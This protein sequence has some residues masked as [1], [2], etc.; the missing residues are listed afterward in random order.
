MPFLS[1][2]EQQ[3]QK[4]EQGVRHKSLH[5]FN[6]TN[7]Y[8]LNWSGTKATFARIRIQKNFNVIQSPIQTHWYPAGVLSLTIWILR[9]KNTWSFSTAMFRRRQGKD[10]WTIPR[11]WQ[12]VWMINAWGTSQGKCNYLLQCIIESWLKEISTD[13]D[14]NKK[15]MHITIL[16]QYGPHWLKRSK[17]ALFLTATKT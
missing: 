10:R 16:L 1:S 2:S 15:A 3:L 14:Y 12:W 11:S 4:L 8:E 13:Y 17:V 6:H 5:Y 9:L 7:L